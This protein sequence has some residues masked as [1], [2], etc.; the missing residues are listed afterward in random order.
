[1]IVFLVVL[2]ILSTS[3][4]PDF[5]IAFPHSVK[6]LPTQTESARYKNQIYT[7]QIFPL[8]DTNFFTTRKKI[9]N[10]SKKNLTPSHARTAPAIPAPT[11]R[12]LCPTFI[13]AEKML[14]IGFKFASRMVINGML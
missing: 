12:C 6:F 13:H 2:N 5:Y 9:F 14:F 8:H 1:M 11:L 3:S 4:S 10:Y 7:I